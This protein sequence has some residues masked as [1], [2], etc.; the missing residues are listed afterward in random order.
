MSP[1]Q[2]VM[3]CAS[4]CE[5]IWLSAS[6]GPHQNCRMRPQGQHHGPEIRVY[7]GRGDDVLLR[8]HS[9]Q[10]WHTICKLQT[11]KR[12]EYYS[13][14]RWYGD[15]C[16]VTWVWPFRHFC[17]SIARSSYLVYNLRLFRT[18]KKMD[19]NAQWF[20]SSWSILLKRVVVVVVVV[21]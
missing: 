10:T 15:T 1:R 21:A 18:V 8:G 17:I 4:Y 20:H 6:I 2:R 16:T 14:V 7:R 5:W 13:W 12:Y 9:R 19:T 3:S 11:L